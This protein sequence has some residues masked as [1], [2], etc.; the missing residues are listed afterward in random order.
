LFDES[1]GL[2]IS[3]TAISPDKFRALAL[4]RLVLFGFQDPKPLKLLEIKKR[5]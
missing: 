1:Q 3:A 2:R 5:P 4:K